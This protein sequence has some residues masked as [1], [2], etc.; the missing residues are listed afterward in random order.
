[1]PREVSEKNWAALGFKPKRNLSLP[2]HP[3][4]GSICEGCGKEFTSQDTSFKENH[5]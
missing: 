5:K 2:K 4:V 1:M 3:I